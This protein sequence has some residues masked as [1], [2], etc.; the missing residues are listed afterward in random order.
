M[1]VF[2]RRRF[3]ERVP[4]AVSALT[5]QRLVSLSVWTLSAIAILVWIR[6]DPPAWDVHI[7]INAVRSLN[8]GHDP[9]A[10]AMAIQRKVHSQMAL[11]PDAAVSYSYVYSPITLLVL[12]LVA[13][14]PA[15]LSGTVYWSCYIAGILTPLWFSWQIVSINERPYL[16]YLFPWIIF[17]P[18]LLVS[19]SILSGN[20]AFIIYPLVLS[21]ALP[22]WR[23]NRWRYFYLAVV[24]AS[25]FKIPLLS[26]LVIPV[27]S[28]RKQWSAAGLWAGVGLGLFVLQ[29]QVWPLLFQHYLQAVE[30]Q[31][32]Y[33]RDFGSSPAGIVSGILFDHNIPYSPACIFIYL[34]YALPVFKTLFY[35]SRRFIAGCIS[36]R[37][38]APVLLLGTILLN[39]RIIEYDVSPIGLCMALV[40]WRFFRSILATGAAL[41]SSFVFFVSVNV[42][43]Y[44]SW[45]VWKLTEAALLPIT[46]AAGCWGV[47]NREMNAHA[48]VAE[49]ILRWPQYASVRTTY[50]VS[51]IRSSVSES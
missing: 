3:S 48:I 1:V 14:M 42:I 36:L 37:Q 20:I 27:L 4:I 51:S 50:V 9:Y 16:K 46:F 6:S 32:S 44:Q 17:F 21:A 22:G 47:V 28:A 45:P 8:S 10:D 29:A 40:V 5:W 2:A 35:I 41:I 23:E 33:N 15:W 19:D 13:R 38:W 11:Y 43:A 12:Q 34:A 49:T 31:F 30:L 18:G 24:F 7:Y 39:P 25:C 26:L